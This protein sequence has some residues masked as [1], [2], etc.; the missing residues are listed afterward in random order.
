MSEHRS[1]PLSGVRVLDLT[2]VQ[3]GPQAT[4]T[5]ADFGADVIK[6][7][8]PG[9]GDISRSIDTESAGIEDSAPFHSLNRN[10]RSIALDLKQSEAIGFVLKLLSE[11]DV[12]V[13]N[14]RAGVAE[15][16]GLGWNTL[17]EQFPHLIYA[18]GTGFGDTGPLRHLGGQ[19][20][21]L[22][23][24][25]GAAWH[26]RGDD[27]RPGIYP[28]SFI[29]FGAGMALVQGILLALIERST[30]GL[31]QRVDVSLLDTVVYQQMQE[32]TSWM[33][34]RHEIHWERD[35]LVG[36][37][38]TADGW[39]TVV[40][41]FRPEPLRD[42]CLA[43][44]FEDLSERPE[45]KT[46]ELQQ[47]N[48]TD[49]W[50]VLDAMFSQF[51]T[52]EIVSKL[53]QSGILCGPVLDYD[54]VLDNPQV[55]HNDIIRTTHHQVAGDVRVPD[56]PIKLSAAQDRR[57]DAAPLLGEH[58]DEILQ[59]AGYTPEQIEGLTSRHVV[60]DYHQS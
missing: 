37:F 53:G 18:Y 9:A 8:R 11:T 16:M 29:D 40:G 4:Q 15:R 3:F 49:L 14:Y 55:K 32:M 22:Q 41:M 31:G 51:S 19:D 33:K 21:A 27:G 30:S 44:E 23:S 17:H 59:E 38:K 2:Q 45:F 42:V 6:I 10:K 28:V 25:G 52:D 56:N 48:R 7:E 46:A 35:N 43:L 1:L 47:R 50:K 39:V 60:A 13:S 5:L 34:R 12:L 54:D 36:A 57:Y 24:F 58:T 26:N 20:M